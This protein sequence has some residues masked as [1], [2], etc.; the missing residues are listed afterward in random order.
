M[1]IN[2]RTRAGMDGGH[3]LGVIYIKLDA[4][5]NKLPC[6][7]NDPRGA[8]IRSTDRVWVRAPQSFCPP[9]GVPDDTLDGYYLRP[10]PAPPSPCAAEHTVP[11]ENRWSV[12]DSVLG[13]SVLSVGVKLVRIDPR[14]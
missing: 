12:T 11:W 5:V 6:A 4:Q 10:P 2:G 13:S 7:Q 3:G 9:R 1:F 8:A 14:T